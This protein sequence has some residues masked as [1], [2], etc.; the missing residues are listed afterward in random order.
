MRPNPST[1]PSPPPNHAVPRGSAARY[2]I[3]SRGAMGFPIVPVGDKLQR[4]VE[5]R[6]GRRRIH[7]PSIGWIISHPLPQ[8]DDSLPSSTILDVYM[9]LMFLYAHGGRTSEGVVRFSRY[10]LLQLMGWLSRSARGGGGR[11]QLKPSGRH[12]RQLTQALDYLQDT[13]FESAPAR[14][15]ADIEGRPFVGRQRFP[16]L[17]YVKV[18]REKGG[19]RDWTESG[20][21][22]VRL[23]PYLVRE[24]RRDEGVT[25][26]NYDIYLSLSPGTPRHLFR[27]LA[28]ARQQGRSRLRLGELF[29][30]LGSSQ[31]ELIPARARQILRKPHDELRQRGILAQ[32][33]EYEKV[34]GEWWAAYTFAGAERLLSWE[35]LLEG[36]A[37]AW[38]VTPPA[39]REVAVA[40]R[41]QA[42]RVLAAVSRGYLRPTRSLPGMIVH[43]VRQG[44]PIPGN[45]RQ[46]EP[47]QLPLLDNFE[48]RY[49]HWLGEERER[50]L[51]TRPDLDVAA[52]RVSLDT[53]NEAR[54][55]PHPEWVLEGLTEIWL[56]RELGLE[57][58]R[59]YARALKRDARPSGSGS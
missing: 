7:Y 54:P 55:T 50:R 11:R 35:D 49:L 34:G 57:S 45:S 17:T 5:E 41:F 43:Y 23:H 19:R 21:S 48:G 44:H 1:L 2:T 38:G 27:L 29:E 15:H 14:Q 8:G 36:Q 24:L 4:N 26:L 25:R 6:N 51:D 53:E 3:D 12:Y 40:S 47:E 52:F 28:W 32:S 22:E 13:T 56:N 10:Q 20:N 31:R 46:N 33:P 16:I 42:E 37:K 9:A 59:A 30:R 39:A 58:I 18:A